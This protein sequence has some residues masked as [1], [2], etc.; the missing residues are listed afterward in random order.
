MAKSTNTH[1]HRHLT[2]LQMDPPPKKKSYHPPTRQTRPIHMSAIPNTARKTAKKKEAHARTQAAVQHASGPPPTTTC[3]PARTYKRSFCRPPLVYHTTARGMVPHAA[4]RYETP[5]TVTSTFSHVRHAHNNPQRYQN[6]RH[7]LCMEGTAETPL[8]MHQKTVRF[9][10]TPE[11]HHPHPAHGQTRRYAS[12]FLT[13]K[14]KLNQQ[15]QE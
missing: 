15:A 2:S 8:T 3:T 12:D 7:Q 9:K 11:K 14:N 10:K 5:L 13:C 1:A 4:D 6:G